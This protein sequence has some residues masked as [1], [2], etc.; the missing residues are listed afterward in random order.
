MCLLSHMYVDDLLIIAP[1]PALISKLKSALKKRFSMSDLGEVKYLLGWSIQR[2][3]KNRTIFIHQHKYATK[4]IDRFSDYIPYPIATPAERNAK[5]SVSSQPSSEQEKDAMSSIPYRQAVGS[6]M[7]LMVG[8]RPD[9]SFYMREGILDLVKYL[10]GTKEY[11]L[12]LGG[13]SDIT[14]ENLAD[15]LLAYS[16]SD[17]ANCPDTRRSVGGYVTMLASSPIS[18]L[19][20][21]HHTVV[22]STT[23]A[24]YI[25]LCHCMQEMIFLKLLLKELGF[26]ATQANTIYE[27][28]Q[29]CIKI[30]YNPELHGRSKHIH[31]RYCFVQEKVER[32]EFNVT[33]CNTKEMIADIF[34]KALD[35]HQFRELRTKLRMKT[36]E[37]LPGHTV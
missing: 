25:A 11:G 19:S 9:M 31:V 16:D 26:A 12:L 22:L 32:H 21:K 7:Y 30:C 24:E 20:R 23:E 5:L 28:S 18:W 6:V 2:D 34:T 36:L 4:V 1:T 27:D 3:R 8:T 17:Y 29:S 15:Q 13:S 33:Y 10:S 14:S 37:A 35:K